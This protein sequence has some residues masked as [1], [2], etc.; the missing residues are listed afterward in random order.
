M[1]RVVI[2]G[3]GISV[4]T[5]VVDTDRRRPPVLLVQLFNL[6]GSILEVKNSIGLKRCRDVPPVLMLSPE[7]G[8]EA[9]WCYKLRKPITK[10]EAWCR[11]RGLDLNQKDQQAASAKVFAS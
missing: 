4:V 8:A 9:R 11:I 7:D 10:A 5:N 3:I 2:P 6:S 1:F